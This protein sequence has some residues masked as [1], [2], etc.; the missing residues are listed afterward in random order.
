MGLGVQLREVDI[1]VGEVLVFG[2]ADRELVVF[3]F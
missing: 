1:E 3:Y 2:F